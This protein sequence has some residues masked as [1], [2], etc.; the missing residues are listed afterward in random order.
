[1]L[2]YEQAGVA[3]DEKSAEPAD[4]APPATS[5]NEAMVAAGL[6]RVP[7]GAPS[8]ARGVSGATEL[9]A[10]VEAAKTTAK[11]GRLGMWRYGE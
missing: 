4:E 6:A 5:I 9:L 8:T 2:E 7:R 11:Q 10:R 3:G 1:M